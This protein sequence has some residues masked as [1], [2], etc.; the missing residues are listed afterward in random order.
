MGPFTL[1]LEK[2]SEPLFHTSCNAIEQVL[3][4]DHKISGLHVATAILHQAHTGCL[5]R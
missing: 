4:A 3:L 5:D 2:L 1:L